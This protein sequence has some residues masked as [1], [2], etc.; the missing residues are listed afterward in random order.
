MQM[1]NAYGVMTFVV[2]RFGFK[3][4]F[5]CYTTVGIQ[6][7]FHEIIPLLRAAKQNTFFGRRAHQA[8]GAK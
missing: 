7:L 3:N 4:A 5:F 1:K 2:S 6:F 8:V